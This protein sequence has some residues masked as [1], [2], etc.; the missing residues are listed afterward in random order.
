MQCYHWCLG[1]IAKKNANRAQI[2]I[3]YCPKTYMFGKSLLLTY[4][5]SNF[6]MLFN[7]M[8]STI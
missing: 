3:K 8:F 2:G 5:Y 4:V 7:N 1:K 6:I